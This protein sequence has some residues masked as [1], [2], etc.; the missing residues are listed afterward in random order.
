LLIKDIAFPREEVLK[1]VILG[2]INIYNVDRIDTFENSPQEVFDNTYPSIAFKNILMSISQKNKGEGKF[3]TYILSGGYGTG[4]SHLLLSTFHIFKNPARAKDWLN[5]NKIEFK[6]I[7]DFKIISIHLLNRNIDYLWIPIFEEIGKSD[8]L[9]KIKDFPDGEMME[10]ILLNQK[11]VIIFDELESWYE[12]KENKIQDRNLNFLQILTELSHK[13]EMR[14]FVF[15]AL[16]GKNPEIW[17]RIERINPYIENLTTSADKI[18]IVLFRLFKKI[19]NKIAN[20]I[21]EKYI[22]LYKNIELKLEDFD[23]LERKMVR[24]YPFHPELVDVLFDRFSSSKNYGNTRGVLYLLSSIVRREY[25]K[26]DLILISDIKEEEDR[27]LLIINRDLVEKAQ[28]NIQK[29]KSIKFGDSILKTILIY[30]LGDLKNIGAMIPQIIQGVIRIGLNINEIHTS[31]LELEGNASYLWQINDRYLIKPEENLFVIIDT[32]TKKDIEEGKI[33]NALEFISKRIKNIFH[34]SNIFIYPLEKIPDNKEIIYII[35]L[36]ALSEQEIDN[37]Y[38]GKQYRNTI[39]LIQ[40]KGNID[41]QKE[42]D[43]LIKAQRIII[44]EEMIKSVEKEKQGTIRDII[45]RNREEIDLNLG[46]KYGNWIKNIPDPS[47]NTKIIHRFVGCELNIISIKKKLKDYDQDSFKHEIKEVL[48][49]KKE[50]GL[51]YESLL[52]NLYCLQGKPILFNLSILENAI[53]GLINE[54]KIIIEISGTI[55]P[56]ENRK[57]PKRLEKSM[58]LKLV[59]Y[60]PPP[61][62]ILPPE[63]TIEGPPIT[64]SE[65]T[66]STKKEKPTIEPPIEGPPTTPSEPAVSTKKEKPT[67]EPK[68]IETEIIKLEG[69]KTPYA[70]IEQVERKLGPDIQIQSIEI[71]IKINEQLKRDEIIK[72]IEKLPTKSEENLEISI[73]VV[74]E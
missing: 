26:K 66:V 60:K 64:P 62:D 54:E 22:Q 23:D 44:A 28:L 47:E 35:S 52:D 10:K 21:I 1:D 46:S 11:L 43:L 56:N 34:G 45:K 18:D 19:N 32:K 39:I 57:Y 25:D 41:I 7:N 36:F 42:E 15:I 50:K 16:Y 24:S 13:K 17:G 73:K 49:E 69:L 55:F 20:Q 3:G 58:L 40:P 8:L 71:I 68:S 72:I 65:S 9:S 59:K 74:K 6:L 53:K 5:K 14:I 70:L 31:L 27:E 33:S 29:C 4:K 51:E 63:S 2:I 37:I 48:K 38:K 61:K 12:G 30:S 67:I